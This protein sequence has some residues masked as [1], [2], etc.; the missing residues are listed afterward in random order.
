[1]GGD[2]RGKQSAALVIYGNQEYSELRPGRHHVESLPGARLS[3]E[4]RQLD[5]FPRQ[6]D[7][8]N[9]AGVYDRAALDAGIE[10]SLA[11]ER[12]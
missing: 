5:A 12:R 4:P 8:R 9:P 1:M 2:K 3:G 11:A 6:A 7:A 10:R